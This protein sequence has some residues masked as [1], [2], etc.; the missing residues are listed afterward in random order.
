M[1]RETLIK[2]LEDIEWEDFEVKEAHAELPKNI[3]ETVSAFSNTSGGWIMLGIKQAGKKY[4]IK[5]V[6]NPEKLEQ[7]F[8][9]TLRGDKFNVKIRPLCRKYNFPEGTVLA[10][11]IPLSDKKPV[12]YNT[13][14][15][16][17]IRTGSGDQKA[18]K[19]EIDA[20][21]R[22][23][24]FGTQSSKV[25]PDSSIKHL[26]AGSLEQYRQYVRRSSPEHAYNRL[27][28][29][30]FLS[31]LRMAV[32]GQLTYCGLLFLG[33]NDAIQM[34][35]PDFRIDYLEI[36]GTSY[37]DA[38]VRYTFRL[39]EQENLWQY[40]FAL[41]N[42]L[43]QQLDLPFKLTA[44]G[45]ASEDYPQLGALREALVN[46]LMHTDYFSPAKPRIRV[47]DDRM[48]FLNPGALP[49]PLEKIMAEDLSLPRNPILA[50]LF[51]VARL[52][53]NAGY[54]FDKMVDGWQSYTGITPE[55]TSDTSFTKSVFPK[56]IQSKKSTE[57]T[58]KV[59]DRVGEK[60][61]DRVG[62]NLTDNQ[63]LMVTLIR[64]DP[65]VSAKKLAEKVGISSR[66]IEE[67]IKKLKDKGVIAR[68]GPAKGGYWKILTAL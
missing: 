25:I 59:G 35:F 43:R 18:T 19:E 44:D 54:G 22:D 65:Y 28:D 32:D 47:F 39:D 21:Y 46:L 2:K 42:R 12:Y 40:F 68:I 9:N 26:H 30:D 57:A 58:E 48:E 34:H 56:A 7:D 60:V 24:A 50:K 36:P 15:N 52:A 41:F 37:S 17:F 1:T 53:E 16:T 13:Q 67:N 5:G 38:K 33:T 4:E 64:E 20:M 29:E 62:E 8:I 31:K 3:W 23:Q 11:Y 45:F 14:A 66:K 51:R 61:G 10:F 63:Q 55:F 49:E 6:A 27:T